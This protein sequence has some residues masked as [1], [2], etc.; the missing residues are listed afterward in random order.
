MSHEDF[1]T[2]VLR[3]KTAADACRTVRDSF[4]EASPEFA[5][6]HHAL[7]IARHAVLEA[8]AADK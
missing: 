4:G 6:A 2:L 1:Y 5:K 8:L 7:L 3:Y